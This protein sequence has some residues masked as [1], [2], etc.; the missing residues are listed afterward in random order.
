VASQKNVCY[1]V[2]VILVQKGNPKN[3]KT[4][5]DLARPG[6]RL[7]IGNPK[8][9][10]VGRA[11]EQIFAKNGI[12]KDAIEKNVVFQSVTVSELG[13][14]V[15]MG[16]LD[17]TIVWDATAAFY[18]D[19]ADAIAIPPASSEVSSVAV[20]I[21]KC[22]EQPAPAQAFVDFLAS[23]DGQAIFRKQHYTTE[24]PK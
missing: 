11:S 20:A 1:F 23:P 12:A 13:L 16:Q 2:P 3:I 21:L 24:L 15:T 7:G 17:A 4:L 14:Q 8:A 5:A 18:V 9:C 10:Q 22:S 6:L 19:K